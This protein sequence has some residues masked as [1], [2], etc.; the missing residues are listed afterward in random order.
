MPKISAKRQITLPIEHC[1][2]LGFEPGD[3]VEILAANGVLTVIKK[4]PGAARG[5]LKNVKGNK[6][7]SDQESLRSSL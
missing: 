4:Q 7:I 6:R 5:L 1:E 3:D 2:A